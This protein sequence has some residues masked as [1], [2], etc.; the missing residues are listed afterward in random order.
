V[1]ERYYAGIGSRQTPDRVEPCIREIV[2]FLNE[3]GYTLRSGGAPGADSMFERYATRKQ[4]FLPWPDFNYNRSPL[5]SP[6][7]A[8][9]EMAARFHPTWYR[10]SP[11]ARRLQARNVHQ[12]LGPNLDSYSDF[13]VCWTLDGLVTGGTGQALRIALAYGI[14][15]VN[16][17]NAGLSFRWYPEVGVPRVRELVVERIPEL[18]NA[19]AGLKKWIG[20]GLRWYCDGCGY[21]NAANETHCQD[22]GWG[23]WRSA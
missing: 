7:S 20:G 11:G 12:V 5:T 13:V 18:R 17:A 9:F 21:G 6:S 19:L 14:P 22:C 4:I 1:T 23:S 8:A 16:L 3:H 2:E 10:L 15:I